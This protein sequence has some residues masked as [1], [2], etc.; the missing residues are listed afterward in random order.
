LS[1]YFEK[2]VSEFR[3]WIK[4]VENR[5]NIDEEV[6]LIKL[7]KIASNYII[8]DV[9]GLMLGKQFIEKEFKVSPENFAEFI[10][11][12]YEN[13]ISSKIAKIV[14]PEMVK[15]GKDPSHIV[16]DKGLEQISDEGKLE[17]V[18]KMI[19]D[20]NPKSVIDYK[21]GKEN[22][23]QFLAGQVMRETKGAANPMKIQEMLK[24][25]LK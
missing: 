8:S 4:D 18:I 21:A 23:L 5:E 1:E 15:T 24:N 14:L 11:M 9:L 12:I 3:V 22:A 25:I 7:N 20:S 2:V 19:I 10:T 6:E 16:E 17:Q 13:K